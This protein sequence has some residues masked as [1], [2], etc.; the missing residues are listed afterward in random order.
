M[1][2]WI[3]SELC[4]SPQLTSKNATVLIDGQS[5]FYEN[6]QI[7]LCCNNLKIEKCASLIVS[8]SM[9][10][11]HWKIEMKNAMHYKGD[12]CNHD[13][14]RKSGDVDVNRHEWSFAK[15]AAPK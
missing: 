9:F 5:F 6:E 11:K 15:A 12:K 4:F 2:E 1:D 7:N 14:Q 13:N 3:A 8:M 10:Q